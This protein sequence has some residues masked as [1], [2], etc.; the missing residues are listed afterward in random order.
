M[1]RCRR[2][3]FASRRF[4]F[5]EDVIMRFRT[6]YDGLS[7]EVSDAT[8]LDCSLDEDKAVQSHKG[9]ADINTIVRRFGVTGQP[10]VPAEGLVFGDFSTVDSMHDALQL[11]TQARE[12]FEKLPAEVQLEF[13]NDPRKFWDFVHDDREEYLEGNQRRAEKLGLIVR[14]PAEPGPVRVEVVNPPA[15]GDSAS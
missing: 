8:G 13:E 15:A 11:V 1:W 4:F 2:C 10:L 9:D 7:D 14:K 3:Y 12:Q 5:L 6:Q